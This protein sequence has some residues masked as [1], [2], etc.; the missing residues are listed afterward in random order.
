MD[1]GVGF[2]SLTEGIDTK[3]PAGRMLLHVLGA[4][5]QFER[6]LIA[7]RTKA[8][9]QAAKARGK[10]FGPKQVIDIEQAREMFRKGKSM[11]QVAD[12]FGVTRQALYRYFNK[13][14]VVE[15]QDEGRAKRRR[16]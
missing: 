11:Q 9:M 7:E 8:G 13:S 14:A 10:R 15:L 12:H 6:D 3:T 1:R 2:C 16:K 4:L 5:A